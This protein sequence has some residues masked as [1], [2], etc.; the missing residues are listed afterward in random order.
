MLL[1]VLCISPKDESIDGA[2]GAGWGGGGW[3]GNLQNKENL[4]PLLLI[5]FNFLIFFLHSLFLVKTQT[6]K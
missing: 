4:I 3:N 2:L 6:L 5:P 1:S